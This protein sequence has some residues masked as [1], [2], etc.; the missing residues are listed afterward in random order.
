MVYAFG[1]R[2]NGEIHVGSSPTAHILFFEPLKESQKTILQIAVIIGYISPS[3]SLA[4]HDSVRI[5][6][7][8]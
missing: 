6:P 4:Q 3:T 7:W 8:R 2:S 1:L 5:P